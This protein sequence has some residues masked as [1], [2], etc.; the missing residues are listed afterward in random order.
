M[1][2]PKPANHSTASDL[3]RAFAL[4]FVGATLVTTGVILFYLSTE[5]LLE[6][7]AIVFGTNL[8]GELSISGS[9][10]YGAI[11][12]LI[13]SVPLL[14][15]ISCFLHGKKLKN[16]I[17][18]NRLAH[19]D[20]APVLYL[21]SFQDDPVMAETGF[22]GV[23]LL[24]TVEEQIAAVMN[25]IG[26]FTAVGK[27]GEPL[28][29]LGARRFYVANEH[30]QKK[31][32][33]LMAEAKLVVLRAGET[34]GFWWELQRAA[35]MLP[36]ER[37]L[38]LIPFNERRYAAFRLKAEQA[39]PRPLP[40]YAGKRN[41]PFDL[42]G[43]V[44][45][46]PDGTPHF[47]RLGVGGLRDFFHY[48]VRMP[49]VAPLKE[50]LHPV[51]QHLGIQWSPPKV[52]WGSMLFVGAGL[53]A[54]VASI[55]FLLV[56]ALHNEPAGDPALAR[57][58]AQI[59]QSQ[60]IKTALSGLGPAEAQQR[61]KELAAKGLKR[62]DD[63]MLQARAR[64][65]EQLLHQANTATCARLL[66]G[67]AREADLLP[68]L[69]KLDLDVK[70]N[71]YDMSLQSMLAEVRKAP[72]P[73]L[74]ET[75]IEENISALLRQL[76]ESDAQRLQNTLDA[77]QQASDNDACWAG[78]TLYYNLNRMPEPHR[79]RLARLLVQE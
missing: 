21:R 76:S 14:G 52:R 5:R 33:E 16:S 53:T 3:W 51:Y 12:G 37:L 56:S 67:T 19:D 60:E 64:I 24:N 50:A 30:W 4:Q 65:Y 66:R 61:S 26:P 40:D 22:V 72:S 55:I 18:S 79:S 54:L 34:D 78:R 41:L 29:Q 38:L 44:Y 43:F 7:V 10:L 46:N 68:L 62:L 2:S 74:T 28:P 49:L 75:Q 57:F 77:L 27:P 59:E 42:T 47:A 6:L 1:G 39:F 71:W 23:P 20:R 11:K 9:A 48:S 13:A 36:P 31:V 8:P 69:D 17:L 73:T 70:N 58:L 63:S 25:E 45:F 15:G 32:T 35:A